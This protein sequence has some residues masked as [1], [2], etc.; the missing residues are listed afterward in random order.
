MDAGDIKWF[1]L[2]RVVSLERAISRELESTRTARRRDAVACFLGLCGLRSSEISQLIF[3]DMQVIYNESKGV[4]YGLLRVRTTKKGNDRTLNLHASLV[5]S[6]LGWNGLRSF[7]PNELILP[8]CHGRKVRRDQ[9]NNTAK[10]IFACLLGNLHGLTFHSLRHTF[11]MRA[12]AKTGDIR[13][14]QRKLGHTAVRTTEVYVRSL[15][16]LPDDCMPRVA[17]WGDGTPDDYGGGQS[18]DGEM[19]RAFTVLFADELKAG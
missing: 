5:S 18:G 15:A 11:A 16:E 7:K 19:N 6:M 8:N 2:D 10:K 12:Y 14:V 9:F 1:P 4:D 3:R 13:L 17:G